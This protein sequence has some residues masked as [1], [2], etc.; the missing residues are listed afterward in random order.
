MSSI[1]KN[2]AF[3]T[4]ASVGQKIISFVY[5]AIV[6]GHI[7]VANTG[8]YFF[9]LSFTTVFVVFVDLGLTNVLVREGARFR[10][11]GQ[12]YLGTILGLKLILGVLSY[13]AAIIIIHL[14]RYPAE[15]RALIY[16]SGVT[17]LFDSTHLTLYGVLRAMGHLQ[18][19]SGSIVASQ[20]ITLVLGTAFLFFG[21]PLIFLILAFTIPSALNV[22]FAATV[23]ARRYGV[24]LMPTYHRDTARKVITIAI[25]FAIAAVLARLYSY[26]DTMILSKMAGDTAIGLYSIAYKVTFAFQFVPLALVAAT[27]P[28]FSE[29]FAHNR[30]R[31]AFVFERS[32]K[33]LLIIVI[34]VVVGISLLAEDIIASVFK[35]EYIPAIPALRILLISLVFSYASFPI[36]AF[37]NACDRQSIQT[38]IVAG[39]LIVNVAG[40]ILL[41]PRFGIVGSA[42]AALIGNILLT[43]TGYFFIPRVTSISHKYLWKT[44]AQIAVSG[45]IMGAMV[46]Y[47]DKL[48]HYLVAILV[49]AVVYPAML[50]ATG[51]ITRQQMREAMAMVRR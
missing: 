4:L 34:P 24:S 13:A 31:L 44:L 16:L 12:E 25:P 1:P 48:A 27:Y 51:A 15:T 17:M 36:G 50:F 30:G 7:G 49:G 38:K 46:W 33:Y 37:L 28:R 11:K 2:T 45:V 39:A 10:E 47:I 35:P 32:L 43:V 29:Y 8:K 40:N 19:E 14:L 21:F 6:A 23:L 18:Y 41:I 26:A 5:F 3:M 42:Y 22:C 20:L 9:A